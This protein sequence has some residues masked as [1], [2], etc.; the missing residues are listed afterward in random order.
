MNLQEAYSVF[1]LNQ[2]SSQEDIKKRYKELA[3]KYH[4][5]KNKDIDADAKFAKINLAYK[6]LQEGDSH[7]TYNNP[8]QTRQYHAYDIQVGA[9]ISFKESILGTKKD[10]KFN[11]KIKCNPCNGQG[12][13]KKSNGCKA[14]GG[15]GYSSQRNVQGDTTFI[16]I[17]NSCLG[18]SP[19]ENCSYCYNQGYV[20]SEANINVNIPGGVSTG[21]ALRLNGL[22]N[23]CGSFMGMDRTTNA[24][25]NLNVEPEEGLTLQGSDVVSYLKISLKDALVGCKKEIKTIFGSKEV[26]VK[27]LSKNKEEISVKGCGVNKVGSQR[28]ILDVEYPENIDELTAFLS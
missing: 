18:R 10:I 3:K 6:I 8:Q 9:T 1:E 25:V 17:C 15:S 24:Y 22:G 23:F 14:C 11:H 7:P 28:V 20:D 19:V 4:P 12:V 21:T 13:V 26:D 2:T 27:P 16:T 5:D